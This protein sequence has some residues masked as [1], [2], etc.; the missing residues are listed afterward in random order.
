MPYLPEDVAATLHQAARHPD[1]GAPLLEGN[2]E[3]VAALY[4]LHPSRVERVRSVV[5]QPGYRSLA[6]AILAAAE[7]Q[8]APVIVPRPSPTARALIAAPS[9]PTLRRTRA[10]GSL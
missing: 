7:A 8:P 1:G 10:V 2:L 6:E 9:G 5:A 4:Q 3:S